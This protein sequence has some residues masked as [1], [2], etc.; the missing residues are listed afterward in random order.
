MK[1][2]L[3]VVAMMLAGAGPALAQ[4]GHDEEKKGAAAGRVHVHVTDKADKAIDLKAWSATLILET[5][6]LGRKTFKMDLEAAKDGKSEPAH[7]GQV[8]EVEGGYR[9]E[10]VVEK[11]HGGEKE[12]FKSDSH[13]EAAIPLQGYCCGMGGHPWSDKPGKCSKCPM[14]MTPA[15]LEFTAVVIFKTPGGTINAKGFAWPPAMP[16]TYAE[17]MTK[18]DEHLKSIRGL[19]DAGDLDRVHAAAERISQVCEKLP[20]LASKATQA[21][22]D[23]ISKAIVALFKEIDEAADAGKKAETE[24]VYRKYAEKIEALK[25]LAR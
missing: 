14:E 25:K 19:I 15:D 20:S 1:S 13:F 21:E 11:V 24:A 5:K 23:A 8:V 4:H 17:G 9:V 3:V 6:T 22:V 7:E 12:D 10:F 16:T 18:L 2:V